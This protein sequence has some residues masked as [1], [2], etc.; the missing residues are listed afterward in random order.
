MA[1]LYFDK[2]VK[3]LG[4]WQLYEQSAGSCNCHIW[5]LHADNAM[6]LSI[7]GATS[8]VSRLADGHRLTCALVHVPESWMQR[9]PCMAMPWH[10][11]ES[12]N[13]FSESQRFQTFAQRIASPP[14]QAATWTHAKLGVCTSAFA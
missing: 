11:Q 9:W 8:P 1:A 7:A 12:C 3:Q 5:P 10:V 6:P 4:A 13:R 14:M 2:Q